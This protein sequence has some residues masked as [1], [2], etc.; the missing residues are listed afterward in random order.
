MKKIPTLFVRDEQDRR[1]VTR[2][3]NPGCEWVIA[4][5]GLATRKYDGTCVYFDGTAWW[6]R[7]EVKPGKTPPEGFVLVEKDDTT[8][9]AVGWEPAAQS[10]FYKYL[11]EAIDGEAISLGTHELLGPKINGN[12]EGASRHYVQ[13][14]DDALVIDGFDRTYD[15]IRQTLDMH[16]V[17]EGLVFHH[18]DGRMVKIKRRDFPASTAPYAAGPTDG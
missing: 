18:E 12:P 2:E 14:H 17:F 5:E 10:A 4:G 6:A 16:P 9:K 3:V 7:R 15:G 1:Y 13:P 8:G 11:L